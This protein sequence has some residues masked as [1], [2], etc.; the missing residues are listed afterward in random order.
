MSIRWLDC[1][2]EGPFP[3]RYWDPPNS[4]ALYCIMTKPDP[5]KNPKS[6]RILYFGKTKDLRDK[7]F[8]RSHKK[9]D[10]WKNFAGS[11]DNL[12]IG[13]YS[14]PN[15]TAASRLEAIER[16]VDKYKPVCNY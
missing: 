1:V 13:I 6:F 7:N 10:C 2:F 16:L 5:Q 3:I 14:M 4:P 12:F 11:D 15:S 9:M 8:W